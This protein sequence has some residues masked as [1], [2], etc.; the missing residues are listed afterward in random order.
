MKYSTRRTLRHLTAAAGAA[1]LLL[2]L[3]AALPTASA[4][5]A[6][7]GSTAAA[8]ERFL[9]ENVWAAGKVLEIG[10]PKAQTTGPGAAWTAAAAIFA[11]GTNP[12]DIAEQVVLAYPVAGK[13]STYVFANAAGQVL[14]RR[15]NDDSNYRYLTLSAKTVDEAASDPYAQWTAVDAGSGAVFLQNVQRDGNGR[16]AALDMY[17]WMTADGSE[18]QSYDA[19]TADVQRWYLRP[20]APEIPAYSG[21]T[22]TGVAPALPASRSARYSWGTTVTVSPIT[23]NLPDAAAWNTDGTVTVTGTGKGYFGEDLT[24]TAEIVVGSLGDGADASLSTFAGVT[25]KQLQMLAPARVERSVSGSTSTVSAPVT[26]DWSAVTDA[27]ASQPGIFTVPAA[28]STGFAAKLVV[29]VIPA[30]TVNIATGSGIHTGALGGDPAG[31]RDGNRNVVALSDWRSGGATNRVNP[32]QAMYYFDQPRQITGAAVFDLG[33]D[34]KLN[35]G[36]VTVQYRD[37]LGGWVNLPAKNLSWPYTNSGAELRLTVD[38]DP[39]LATGARVQFSN[40]SNAT[41]MTLSEF[42]VY[43]PDAATPVR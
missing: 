27:T 1:A 20:L 2:G 43:G 19:G 38:S 36:T 5:A 32:N 23:W 24:V 12:A 8:P 28:A 37:L 39:V 10:N 25:L 18:I 6:P 22:D 41:W 3:S 9:V 33:T 42:E 11:R 35:I 21:R 29:T 30:D 17:N 7:E 13:A 16:T 40:K 31:L 26:W 14:A 4:D 34:A 15:A